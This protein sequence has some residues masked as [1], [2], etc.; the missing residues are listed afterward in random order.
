MTGMHRPNLI[1]RATLAAGL[2]IVVLPVACGREP[3]APDAAT[4]VQQTFKFTPAS[5]QVAA[6]SK[7]T[8]V[9]RDTVDHTITSGVPGSQSN[10]F[11]RPLGKKAEV[12]IGFPKPGTFAYFC[13]IHNSMRGEIVVT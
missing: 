3:A 9:N 4:V 1:G 7:V 5:V 6:G 13:T 2:L 10:V 11:D 12:V 8:W